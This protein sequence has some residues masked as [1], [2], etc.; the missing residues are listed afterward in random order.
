MIKIF[1]LILLVSIA[2]N[3]WSHHHHHHHHGFYPVHRKEN[4]HV[5]FVKGKSNFKSEETTLLSESLKKSA[6]HV[7]ALERKGSTPF[8]VRRVE[9]ML[10]KA[11]FQI[12]TGDLSTADM[13]LLKSLNYTP[14]EVLAIRERELG[15]RKDDELKRTTESSEEG[16][17]YEQNLYESR[18]KHWNNNPMEY[19][20]SSRYDPDVSDKKRNRYGERDDKNFDFDAYNRQAVIDYENLASKL[21]LQQQSWSEATNL[22]YEDESR[23]V[24][25][26]D[27]SQNLHRSFDR[28]M[29]PHVIFKIPYDDSEFDS[30]SGSDEKSKFVGEGA[31]ASSKDPKHPSTLRHTTAR[32]VANSFHVPSLSTTSSSSAPS[33]ATGHTPLPIVYQLGNIKDVRSNYTRNQSIFDTTESPDLIITSDIVANVS[34]NVTEFDT[35]TDFNDSFAT[36]AVKDNDTVDKKISE[37]E[38]LEWVGEDV[39]R[40]IPAFADSLGYVDE[41]ETSDYDEQ[42]MNTLPERNENDTLEYQNDALD[43]TKHF[44]ANINA[45]SSIEEASLMNLSAY[46]QLALAHRRDQGQKALENIKTIVL[47]ITGR[48][49]NNSTSTNQIQRERLTMFS[50]TCQIP[51]NTDAE[52]WTDPFSMNIHFQLNLTSGDHVVAAKLRIYK[53]PQENLTTYASGSFDEDED[54]EKKIRISVYYYTKS[55]KRHRSKKRLMDSIVTPLTS[56]GK[57]LVL[58]VRQGVRFWRMIPRSSPHGNGNNHGLVIQIEDQDG[59]ALKPAL[60]LQ[61]PSCADHDSNQK[62]FQLKPALFIRA[63]ARYSHIVNGEKVTYV[64]CKH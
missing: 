20:S 8:S 53:L 58:D 18:A 25:E 61:Q 22:D 4:S 6:K 51:R 31:L 50:P 38:G 32:N 13:L 14:E 37:Y 54:D 36:D 5:N 34:S 1:V 9:K 30:S 23:N 40:V 19:D 49:N 48:R 10:E 21:E 62:A 39:Y 24:E 17:F 11:I 42:M 47:G 26:Q 60:Y 56:Y 28:A 41:N 55:L 64:N 57:Q 45:S 3:T 46:Q 15:K 27:T 12:I 2:T 33:A 43:Q 59:R 44:M 29:E 7:E 16:R 52:A 63:C 35:L